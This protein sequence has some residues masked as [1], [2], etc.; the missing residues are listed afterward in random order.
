MSD[1]EAAAIAV[2]PG[3]HPLIRGVMAGTALLSL[4][5]PDRA[6]AALPPVNPGE[7]VNLTGLEPNTIAVINHTSVGRGE[8]WSAIY[9]TENGYQGSS[10]TNTKYNGHVS[11]NLAFVD[12]GSQGKVSILTGVSAQDQIADAILSFP[13]TAATDFYPSPKR[14]LDTR[15]YSAKYVA[16]QIVEVN[17]GAERAG[18]AAV[19]NITV[20]LAKSPSW[21]A[22]YP[23]A[24]GYNG[25]S[26]VN[27]DGIG[28][29]PTAEIVMIDK[30]GKVCIMGSVD[31]F[32]L[33]VDTY[34]F[35]KGIPIQPPKRILDTRINK[36]KV[37]KGQERVIE[38]GLENAN[39]IFIGKLASDQTDGAGWISVYPTESGFQNTSVINPDGKNPTS[40]LVVTMLDSKGRMSILLGAANATDIIIDQSSIFD[41][42]LLGIDVAK[43][44]PPKRILDSRVSRPDLPPPF[45]DPCPPGSHA[46]MST[47]HDNN[48][49]GI[50]QRTEVL[51]YFN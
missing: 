41:P 50:V 37:I 40:G 1:Y 34:G 29:H 36:D 43:I 25:T 10:D 19:M 30:N 23:C 33:I 14:T 4:I 18:Q 48:G 47:W 51:C 39:K 32:G 46:D 44:V 31:A 20:D 3:R 12:T 2:E 5:G 42:A 49:D 26:S 22:A 21:Y 13:K 27:P 9:T 28:A 7:V 35:L 11:P 16:N 24:E 45:V 17:Y 38:F 8:G 15:S 6:E